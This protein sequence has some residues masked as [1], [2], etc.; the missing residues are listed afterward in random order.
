[1]KRGK[2]VSPMVGMTA[3]LVGGIVAAPHFSLL[4]PPVAVLLAICLVVAA[5]LLRRFPT[6]CM[7]CLCSPFA[8]WGVVSAQTR[9]RPAIDD[10]SRFAG[11]PS[12][13]FVGVVADEPDT[14]V[15]GGVR[16]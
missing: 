2:R 1:M 13:T 16:Y 11:A 7:I 8:V 9:G 6:L 5:F 10:V 15:S 12:Q 14:T 3:A 4:S